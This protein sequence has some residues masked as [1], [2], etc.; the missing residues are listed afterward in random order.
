MMGRKHKI[1]A[2]FMQL[3]YAAREYFIVN[4]YIFI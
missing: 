3:N 4:S 2:I 1:L